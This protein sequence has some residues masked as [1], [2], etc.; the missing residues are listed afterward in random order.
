ML[1]QDLQDVEGLILEPD[2]KSVFA[3]LSVT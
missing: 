2:P 1:Q 3:D